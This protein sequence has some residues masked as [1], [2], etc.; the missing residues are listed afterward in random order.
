MNNSAP[1]FSWNGIDLESLRHVMDSPA[2]DAVSEIFK[3]KSMDHLRSILKDMAQNDSSLLRE[4][5]AD[6]HDFVQ[7]V[8]T[9]K[10]TSED[11][12]MFNQTHEIWKEHGMQ[13]IF[14][15]FFRCC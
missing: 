8:L 12:E 4:L 1:Q 15:L 9:M 5:P 2:D 7:S 10:F 3:S 6:L 11:I 14:I 13:F